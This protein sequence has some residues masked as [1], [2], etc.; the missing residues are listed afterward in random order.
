MHQFHLSRFS[1][2]TTNT[3]RRDSFE[4]K[5]YLVLHYNYVNN[6]S[7][8]DSN[9]RWSFFLLIEANAALLPTSQSEA[10]SAA[11]AYYI[12]FN[13]FPNKPRFLRVYSRSLLKTL[14]EKENLLVTSNFSFYPQ[15][16]QPVWITF[17]QIHQIWNC[18]LQ[19][20]SVSKSLKFVVW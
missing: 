3:C 16:F 5:Q 18:R 7:L 1:S 20:L 17:C 2:A 11:L 12:S 14:R 9:P 15:C 4:V 6:N 10:F 8:W 19:T 13:P